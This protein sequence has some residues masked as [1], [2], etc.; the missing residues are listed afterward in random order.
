MADLALEVDR[1]AQR[2]RELPRDRKP[3]AGALAVVRPEGTEDPL[4]LLFPDPGAAVCDRDVDLSVLGA[5]REIDAAPVRSPAERIREQVRDDLQDAVAVGDDHG[6][7]REVLRVVDPA[8]LRLLAE[9]R[10]RL[11]DEPRHVDLLVA[12]RESARVE[13]GQVEDVADKSLEPA[14]LGRNHVE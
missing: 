11:L 6:L 13:L 9:R 10:V 2:E 3:E 12:N 5:Q 1:P 4:L 14:R 8:R 7:G